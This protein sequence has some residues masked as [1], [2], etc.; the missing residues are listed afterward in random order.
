MT[1]ITCKRGK[2]ELGLVAFRVGR[3]TCRKC[4]NKARREFKQQHP[5]Y[6]ESENRKNREREKGR[7]AIYEAQKRY[8]SKNPEKMTEK[9]KRQWEKVKNQ[10]P[11]KLLYSC[12]VR[13]SQKSLPFNL[14]VEDV[15]VPEICPVLGIPL[16]IGKNQTHCGSPTIDRVVPSKG[17]VRGNICVISHRANTIKNDATLQELEKVL[18]YVKKR[19]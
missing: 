5:D 12:R 7:R 3:K 10:I 17:Y 15:I 4:V 9:S 18:K 1:K 6:R 8:Y 2:R 13:A 14:S 19:I 16:V 11:L